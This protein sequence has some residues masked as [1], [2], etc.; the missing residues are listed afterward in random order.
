MSMSMS[1]SICIAHSRR[2]ICVG[3]LE[4][5]G[6]QTMKQWRYTEPFPHNTNLWR[7]DV[8]TFRWSWYN[9]D[10]LY[11]AVC[12]AEHLKSNPCSSTK[13]E[14]QRQHRVFSV[15][16]IQWQWN[17][18]VILGKEGKVFPDRHRT[19]REATDTSLCCEAI[20]MGTHTVNT[21]SLD[22]PKQ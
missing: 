17:G 14:A 8:R 3:K 10:A 12:H 22:R 21:D 7:T 4:W 5:C 6:Y 11:I 16:L 2:S 1:M 13:Y 9:R 18:D 19:L 15:F 20:D